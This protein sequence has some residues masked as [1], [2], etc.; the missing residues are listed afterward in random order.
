METLSHFLHLIPCPSSFHPSLI[1]FHQYPSHTSFPHFSSSATHRFFITA[2]RRPAVKITVFIKTLISVALFSVRYFKDW[3]TIFKF[4][5]FQ[6]KT[7]TT[8]L[9]TADT[10]KGAY[11]EENI[12]FYF[13]KAYIWV[14]E[15]TTLKL[16]KVPTKHNLFDFVFARL[17]RRI[18]HVVSNLSDFPKKPPTC[19]L[20]SVHAD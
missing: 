11:H 18:N 1:F 13:L 2:P 5:I 19:C 9:S 14:F 8:H 16:L 6:R 15:G 7:K 12:I 4:I 20:C 3:L 10:L 17:S